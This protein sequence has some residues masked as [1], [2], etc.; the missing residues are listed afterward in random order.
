MFPRVFPNFVAMREYV[1]EVAK[2]GFNAVWINPLQAV[3]N[4]EVE[5][6]PT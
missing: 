3:T 6:Y 4:C 1:V 5:K 2:M